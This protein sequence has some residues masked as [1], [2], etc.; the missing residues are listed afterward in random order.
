KFL[1]SMSLR[2]ERSNLIKY[3]RDC[4]V[5]SLLAMTCLYCSLLRYEILSG[6][7]YKNAEKQLAA[8]LQFAEYNSIIP[9]TKDSIEISTDIYADLRTKGRLIDDIDILIAGIAMSNNL[10]LVTHNTSHFKRING[11]EVEDWF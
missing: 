3:L 10:V 7:K 5:A 11:L 2:A 6:L 9:I 8:F 1:V 4:F